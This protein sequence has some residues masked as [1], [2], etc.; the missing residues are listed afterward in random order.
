MKA[1]NLKFKQ[2]TAV[3]VQL[4][5]G[6]W[7]DIFEWLV[8]HGVVAKMIVSTVVPE[9]DRFEVETDMFGTCI[10]R[11]GDWIV[12]SGSVV[13]VYDDVSFSAMFDLDEHVHNWCN[14]IKD[15]ERYDCE[16]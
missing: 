15:E 13:T 10:V 4:Q 2:P 14:W 16:R 8:D 11:S 12:I 6:N 5:P 7:N 1:Y 9:V 3:G